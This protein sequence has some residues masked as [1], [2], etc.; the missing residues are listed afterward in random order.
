[1]SFASQHLDKIEACLL[2]VVRGAPSSAVQVA[3]LLNGSSV[4]LPASTQ[5]ASPTSSVH[6]ALTAS[7]PSV[8]LRHL[9]PLLERTVRRVVWKKQL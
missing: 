8:R 6:S 7:E 4:M 5:G 9:V 3:P 2:D 1:M